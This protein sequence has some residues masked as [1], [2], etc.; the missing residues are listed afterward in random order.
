MH[1]M[2]RTL[3]ELAGLTCTAAALT[4][5]LHH[6]HGVWWWEGLAISW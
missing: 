2:A 4:L 1:G 6:T 3:R 5:W